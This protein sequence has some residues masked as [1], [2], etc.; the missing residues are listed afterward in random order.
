MIKE[1]RWAGASGRWGQKGVRWSPPKK[2]AGWSADK[3]RCLKGSVVGLVVVG[4]VMETVRVM[5]T[6]GQE[7]DNATL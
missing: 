6:R 2:D 4:V 7:T 3:R 5:A 1:K